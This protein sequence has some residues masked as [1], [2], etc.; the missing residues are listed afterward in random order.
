MLEF[1]RIE[2]EDFPIIDRCFCEHLQSGARWSQ[3]D[4]APGTVK[5]WRI[6]YQMEY[7]VADGALYLRA[8]YEEESGT[9]Y[10]MPVGRYDDHALELLREHTE[11]A[12]DATLSVIPESM[13][14]AVAR[15]FCI[16]E[17]SMYA[18]RDW[19][20]YIYLREEL[21]SPKGKKHHNYKYN[22]NRFEK[23][24]PG[25][26]VEAI[27]EVNRDPEYE[28]TLPVILDCEA[29][30]MQGAV[31]RAS[32][33]I[34]G[35]TI[36]EVFGDT[37]IIHTEKARKDIPGAYQTLARGFLKMLSSD[38]IYVNREEDMGLEGLRRSKNS[39]APLRLEYKYT[40]NL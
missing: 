14:S 21:I 3:C 5:M 19:A 17:G 32:G 13:K 31:L 36:G 7:A 22:L 15:V 40:L 38:V 23:E 35:L 12:D 11:N 10:L 34:I 27:T 30:S 25:Y 8:K 24:H 1:K 37:V 33:R 4:Y 6:P 16:P 39:Y 20:D 26:S 29:F 18:D 2:K 28:A 9:S